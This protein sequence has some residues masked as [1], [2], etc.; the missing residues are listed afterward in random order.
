MHYLRMTYL[1]MKVDLLCHSVLPVWHGMWDLQTVS[2]LKECHV[3]KATLMPDGK[4][5]ESKPAKEKTST[6][7]QIS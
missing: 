3:G 5:G 2:E 6:H 7:T 4:L 1:D